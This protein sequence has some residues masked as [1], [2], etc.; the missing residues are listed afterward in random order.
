MA[1]FLRVLQQGQVSLAWNQTWNE[2]NYETESVSAAKKVHQVE[3]GL[4][5]S[6]GHKYGGKKNAITLN[7]TSIACLPEI[8][9][10]VVN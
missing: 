10:W 4:K 1:S 3:N 9:A 6:R 8:V 5:E 7:N 2:T